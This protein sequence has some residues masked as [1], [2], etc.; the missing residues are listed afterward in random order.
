SMKLGAPVEIS[1]PNNTTDLNDHPKIFV[2]TTGTLLVGWADYPNGGNSAT[3]TGVIARST[4]GTTWTRDTLV[5]DADFGTFFWFC[6]GASNVYTAFLEAQSQQFFA[7]VRASA[8]DGATFTATT[9]KAS[10]PTDEIAA[11]DP[12]CVASGSDL[13]VMYGTTQNPS[14]DESTI[15]GADHVYI[16]HSGNAGVS[17]DPSPVDVIDHTKSKLATLPLLARD[18]GGMLDVAYV[19]GDTAGDS[20]GAVRF[21]RTTSA[22]S[23]SPSVFVDGPMEFDL[24]RTDQAWLGDYFGGVAHGGAFYLAYP[25]NETGLDHIYFAKMPLP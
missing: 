2:T 12:A 7:G 19:A 21:T 8:D 6:E 16:A 10:A 3:G 25:R 24:S 14:V 18:D 20:N 11:L 9:V 23:V 5:A 17:F 1:A 22:L 4:N 15:D 13:W